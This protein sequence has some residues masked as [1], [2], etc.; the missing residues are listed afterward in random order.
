VAVAPDP[1]DARTFPVTRTED[2]RRAAEAT[3]DAGATVFAEVVAD[4]SDA[5]VATAVRLITLLNEAWA[6]RDAPAARSGPAWRRARNE[7]SA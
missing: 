2:G 1:R 7:G 6:T 3:V 4:W 5:D